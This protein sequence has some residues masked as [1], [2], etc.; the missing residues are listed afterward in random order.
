MVSEEDGAA[1]QRDWNLLTSIVS[2]P[3]VDASRTQC[4]SISLRPSH[5][6]WCR[7]REQCA[8]TH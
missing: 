1:Q 4:L 5:A 8:N 3:M 6:K 2:L 7:P